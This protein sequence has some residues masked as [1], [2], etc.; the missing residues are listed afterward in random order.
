MHSRWRNSLGIPNIRTDHAEYD[1]MYRH[2]YLKEKGPNTRI[3]SFFDVWFAESFLWREIYS[4]VFN[5]ATMDRVLMDHLG[6]CDIS[7]WDLRA[8]V[9]QLARMMVSGRL[10][11]VKIPPRYLRWLEAPTDTRE[12]GE[13]PTSPAKAKTFITIRV[14][15]H[16]DEP[17]VN[18]P[19]EL[20]LPDGTR[21]KCK[22]NKDGTA[23]V[24]GIAE[25]SCEICFPRREQGDTRKA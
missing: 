12:T 17:V 25:G 18:E 24:L 9:S 8:R 10:V 4:D 5:S 15:D 1:V 21:Q 11:F 6:T 13:P 23:K 20:T 7:H 3:E 2:E 16:N 19:F 22:T 14:V